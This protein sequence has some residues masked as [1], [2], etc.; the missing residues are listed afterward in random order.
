MKTCTA[1]EETHG[2]EAGVLPPPTRTTCLGLACQRAQNADYHVPAQATV[3]NPLNRF[4]REAT[5]V[6]EG[7]SDVCRTAY[8]LIHREILGRILGE[9]SSPSNMR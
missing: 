5:I 1:L 3:V 6:I 9:T 2:Q 8:P 7:V 4:H